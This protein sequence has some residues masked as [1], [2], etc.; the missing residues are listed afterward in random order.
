MFFSFAQIGIELT[1]CGQVIRGGAIIPLTQSTIYIITK[2]NADRSAR[3]KSNDQTEIS[4]NINKGEN[5]TE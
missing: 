3:V 1:K 2:M 5:D 4:E